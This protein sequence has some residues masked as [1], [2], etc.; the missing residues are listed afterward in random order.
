LSYD[1]IRNRRIGQSSSSTPSFQALNSRLHSFIQA[2]DL[3]QRGSITG[4]KGTATAGLQEL[5]PISYIG[6]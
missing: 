1:L 5:E 3:A 2:V 4:Q 6:A